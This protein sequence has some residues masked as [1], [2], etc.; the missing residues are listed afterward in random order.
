MALPERNGSEGSGR[1]YEMADEI[2]AFLKKSSVAPSEINSFLVERG[3]SEINQK[4][5][6]INLATRPQIDLKDLL[7]SLK[8]YEKLM[9]N[10]SSKKTGDN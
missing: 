6:A 2:I 4:I 7:Q 1:N 8:G 9:Y 5:K 3:T 10:N